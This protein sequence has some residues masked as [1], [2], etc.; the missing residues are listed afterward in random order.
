MSGIPLPHP[1]G[2]MYCSCLL[3]AK[4][5]ELVYSKLK[6]IMHLAHIYIITRYVPVRCHES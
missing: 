4:I 6:F 1:K 3:I 5:K 2:K